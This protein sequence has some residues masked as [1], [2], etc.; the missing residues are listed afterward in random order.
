MR[1]FIFSLIMITFFSYSEVADMSIPNGLSKILPNTWDI[2]E[3]SGNNQPYG[4]AKSEEKYLGL[5]LEVSGGNP[6]NFHW[7]KNGNWNS[8]PFAVESLELW[9]MPS[10]YN[11]G[12][13]SWFD[14]KGSKKAKIIYSNDCIK[15]YVFLTHKI[16]NQE[17]FMVA[18]RGAES[19]YWSNSP[20][21]DNSVSWE[22]WE[23]DLV[24]LFDSN[25]Y[26]ITNQQL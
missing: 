24:R 2:T 11:E 12:F 6:V 10:E 19:S 15:V 17:A 13:F 14:F 16:V 8:S 3:A 20:H 21:R 1:I 25:N 9:V 4:L 7:L 5:Y 23:A 22:G 18:V 26:C